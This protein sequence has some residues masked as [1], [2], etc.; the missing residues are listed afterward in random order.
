MTTTVAVVLSGG[1]HGDGALLTTDEPHEPE[2]GRG[3]AAC[4]SILV[5]RIQ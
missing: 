1:V 4:A 3:W 2:Q 5:D